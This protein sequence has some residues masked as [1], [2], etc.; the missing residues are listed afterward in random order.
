LMYLGFHLPAMA[1]MVSRHL[2]A[3]DKGRVFGISLAGSHF[4]YSLA[5]S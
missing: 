1:S 3:A 5:I 4:G 2:T